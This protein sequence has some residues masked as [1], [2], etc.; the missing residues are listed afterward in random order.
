MQTP[1]LTVPF[2]FSDTA[3]LWAKSNSLIILDHYQQTAPLDSALIVPSSEQQ[4]LWNNSIVYT[5]LQEF[6]KKF[7]LPMGDIQ[8]FVYKKTKAKYTLGNPHIDTMGRIGEET[9]YDV[10]FRFNVVLLGDEDTEMTW[11]NIDRNSPMIDCIEFTG[12]NGQLRKRLQVKGESISDR[13]QT[14]GQPQWRSTKLAR[15]T[16]Q[17]SFVRT[18]ILHAINW[19]GANPRFTLSIRFMQNWDHFS[20]LQI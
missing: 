2:S 11:W 9:L 20:K 13:Y 16:Q 1:Y 14:I 6:F 19:T 7:S 8:F 3:W 4:Q 15:L 5:E 10:G 18:D 17:A 12:P